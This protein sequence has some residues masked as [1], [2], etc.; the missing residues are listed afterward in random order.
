MDQT[1]FEALAKRIGAA[2]ENSPAS[3]LSRNLHA[4]LASLFDQADFV[5]REDFDVQKELVERAQRRLAEL[6]ARLAELEARDPPR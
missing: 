6:E 4:L 1:A 2:L 5:L 3:E